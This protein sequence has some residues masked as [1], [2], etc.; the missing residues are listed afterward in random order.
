MVGETVLV[1]GGC[2]FIGL[3]LVAALKAHDHSVRVLDIPRSDFRPVEALGAK[4][5]KG[6]VTDGEAL[7]RAVGNS[8]VVFHLAAP[9]LAIRAE[10]FIHK[11]IAGGAEMLMEEVEDTRVRQVVAASTV[12]V[13]AP[14]ENVMSESAPLATG[15]PYEKAKLEM[16]RALKK[17]ATIADVNVSVLRLGTVYGRGDGCIFDKLVAQMRGSLEEEIIMPRKGWVSTVHVEDVITAAMGLVME[18]RELG[19]RR[20]QGEGWFEV[21]NCVDDMPHSPQGLL[22]AIA[23]VLGIEPPVVKGPGLL[24]RKGLWMERESSQRVVERCLFSNSSLKK[25][26]PDWPRYGSLEEGLRAELG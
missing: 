4:V 12:G 19:K 18:G 1:T 23:P 2:G 7:K 15:N 14:S 6:S 5:V 16:E 17:G 24:R 26:V 11:Q 21:L 10:S 20:K 9:D 22:D 25:E 13:Y 3:R 8:R